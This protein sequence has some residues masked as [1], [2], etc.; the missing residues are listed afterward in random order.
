VDVK[1]HLLAGLAGDAVDLFAGRQQTRPR[2]RA[3]FGDRHA[4]GPQWP[5]CCDRTEATEAGERCEWEWR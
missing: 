4:F 2:Q 1:E 3:G 5:D